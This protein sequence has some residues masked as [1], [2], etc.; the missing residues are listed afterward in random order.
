MLATNWRASSELVVGPQL[1]LGKRQRCVLG[2]GRIHVL[3]IKGHD[4][5]V[6]WDD[7]SFEFFH[8]VDTVFDVVRGV[9]DIS[10]PMEQ[11]PETIELWVVQ[12]E[13][14]DVHHMISYSVFVFH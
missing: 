1:R 6:W 4:R 2:D 9:A 5:E 7:F 12:R 8:Q 13:C 14:L 3:H 10:Y 11:R